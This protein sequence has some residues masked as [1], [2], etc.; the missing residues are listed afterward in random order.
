MLQLSRTGFVPFHSVVFLLPTVSGKVRMSVPL[1]A[2]A[3]NLG[4]FTRQRSWVRAHP[5]KNPTR[6]KC[7]ASHTVGC[8]T[9]S[10]RLL[11]SL[12]FICFALR[13]THSTSRSFPLLGTEPRSNVSA[14]L[15]RLSSSMGFLVHH[16]A[17][18][19]SCLSSKAHTLTTSRPHRC[20]R[21]I[22]AA[23]RARFTEVE[24][25]LGCR[26]SGDCAARSPKRSS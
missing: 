2:V 5:S 8:P 14:G 6:T 21:F 25:A 7:L 3:C 9:A 19:P 10:Q 17:C 12:P 1:A 26:L 16:S 4:R 20:A 13:L 23:V 15:T 18:A 22:P 24:P 11:P